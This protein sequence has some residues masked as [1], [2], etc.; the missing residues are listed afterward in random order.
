VTHHLPIET[1]AALHFALVA[2]LFTGIASTAEL[3]ANEPLSAEE[4]EAQ[5]EDDFDLEERI[6][7]VSDGDLHF[8]PPEGVTGAHHHDNTIRIDSASLR[9]GWIQLR[10]CHDQLDAVPAAQITFRPG[11]IRNLRVELA[12]AIEEAWVEGHTV[13]LKNVGR[14]ARLCI[15][16][17]SRALRYLGEGRYRLQNGPF[18]R[19]FLDGYYPMRV[20]L[21]VRYPES[22]LSLAAWQPA[23]EPGFDLEQGPGQVSIDAAFEGRLFTCL[24]FVLRGTTE[25]VSAPPPCPAEASGT[26]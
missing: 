7:A 20:T 25:V 12:E 19:R 11:H 8:L 17:E 22:A 13:Q 14:G 3:A 24:D 21:D 18:L 5:W 23:T 9:G 6:A 26:R 16:A 4:I 2:F 1:L 10:Q 15:G